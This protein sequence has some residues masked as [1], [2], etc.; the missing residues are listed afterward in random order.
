MRI[1]LVTP[2]GTRIVGI[3]VLLD[4][5][6]ELPVE[7]CTLTGQVKHGMPGQTHI[8]WET[9]REARW[10]FQTP[11][12]VYVDEREDLWSEADLL[13]DLNPFQGEPSD[14]QDLE[15]RAA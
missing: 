9:Q 15:D 5:T 7:L 8:I 2:K 4:A 3:R 10:D 11:S 14:A 6:L 12:Y 13:R 1:P